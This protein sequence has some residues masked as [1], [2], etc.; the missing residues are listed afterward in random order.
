MLEHAIK[1]WVLF[2]IVPIFAFA[3]AGVDLS[4]MTRAQLTTPVTLGTAVGLF[5]GKPLGVAGATWLA[6]KLRVAQL[7]SGIDW[8]AMLGIAMLCGV[9]FTMSLFIGTLAF[10]FAGSDYMQSVRLGVMMGSLLSATDAILVLTS[11]KFPKS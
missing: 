6:I 1:P 11:W 5:I 2:V 4:G 9:G 7:P 8:C 3:N 10:E